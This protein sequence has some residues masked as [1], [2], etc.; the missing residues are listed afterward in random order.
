MGHIV[1]TAGIETNPKKIE[2]VKNW[3]LPRTVTDVRS[4]LGFTNHYRRFIQSYA[5]VARPLNA[6]ISGENVNHKKLLVKWNPECQQ[7]FDQLKDLCAKT[8]ILA[9]ADYKKPFQLQ[10]DASDLGLGAVLYQND[11]HGHQRVIAYASCSL[12]N[13]ERN[14]PVHKLEFLALKWAVTDRFHEYLYGG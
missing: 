14:Y 7:A 12:S 6:L 4:F 8:P 13:T 2:T 11:S 9:Y 5:K 10:T 3:T 1:S